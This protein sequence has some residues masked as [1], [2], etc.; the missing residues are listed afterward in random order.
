ML[1]K[2]A[3][4]LRQSDESALSIVPSRFSSRLSSIIGNSSQISLESAELVYQQLTIDDDLFTTRVYKRNYR[5]PLLLL[6]KNNNGLSLRK[7]TL[8]RSSD[9]VRTIDAEVSERNE[10]VSL[11]QDQLDSDSVPRAQW[12]TRGLYWTACDSID[13]PAVTPPLHFYLKNIELYQIKI[14]ISRITTGVLYD[15]LRLTGKD[16]RIWRTCLLLE[17][18][19]QIRDDLVKILLLQDPT[20]I[21]G[22]WR[23]VPK[24]GVI[25]T[26]SPLQLAVE[27]DHPGLV[28]LLLDK[29][30]SHDAIKPK[31]WAVVQQAWTKGGSQAA[32]A[33]ISS[34]KESILFLAADSL[35]FR[36][37]DVLLEKGI[38]VN[39]KAPEGPDSL[40]RTA[41]HRVVMHIA[42]GSCDCGRSNTVD[43][44]CYGV[45]TLEVLL[46]H[47]ADW[48]ARDSD[49]NNVYH[50]AARCAISVS[51]CLQIVL[52]DI[53][54]DYAKTSLDTRNVYGHTPGEIDCACANIFMPQLHSP[55]IA[56]FRMTRLEVP[57][58]LTKI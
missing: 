42:R 32:E 8:T 23:E 30:A 21:D 49:G 45:Q 20:I 3:S 15:I 1:Q 51:S 13:G 47:G 44:L 36:M 33:L 57:M 16:R 5:H 48:R 25:G 43:E 29:G 37:V 17:A 41:L 24:Y 28:R 22:L 58:K 35:K 55:D 4:I 31:S 46:S 2:G 26:H 52:Q 50:L 19:H 12:N 56:K 18:C 10:S 7:E 34:T 54:P 39:A 53:F 38:Y 6:R 11:L 14:F 27:L 9:S 40:N